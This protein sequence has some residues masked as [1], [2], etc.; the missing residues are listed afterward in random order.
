M[1]NEI[2]PAEEATPTTVETTETREPGI[3]LN[4]DN[5]AYHSGPGV[6]KSGLWTIETKTPSHFK[7]EVRETKDHFEFGSAAHLAILEPEEFEWKVYRGPADRRGNKWKDAKEYCAIE[8]KHLLIEGDYDKVLAIRDTVHA[9]PWINS[10]ITGGPREV[11]A[12]GYWIDEETGVLCR[13]RHDLY[14]TDLGVSIDVKTAANASPGAFDRKAS[15]FGY[16]MQDAFYSD[17]Y[18]AL[19]RE[20]N[21]FVFLAWEKDAPFEFSIQELPPSAVQEGRMA[22]RNA[23]EIYAECQRTGDW[24]GYQRGKEVRTMKFPRWGYKYV[25]NPEE[26]DN[27]KDG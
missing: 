16:H 14:R 13:C 5:D 21:A 24:W 9:N 11:E 19:G 7:N 22:Y 15:D 10:M 27:A 8:K 1:S 23:L 18:R 25:T 17:G 26:L 4:L 20:V 2:V 6:S 3:Y 12:S